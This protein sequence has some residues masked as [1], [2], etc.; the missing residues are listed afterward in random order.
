MTRDEMMQLEEIASKLIKVLNLPQKVITEDMLESVVTVINGIPNFIV[1]E[2]HFSDKFE[3]TNNGIVIITYSLDNSVSENLKFVLNSLCY[4]LLNI[5]NIKN[6]TELSKGIVMQDEEAN[7]LSR[8]ITLP[9][10]VFVEE[11]TANSTNDGLVNATKM[12]KQL[13]MKDSFVV[14]R[15]RDL[16]FFN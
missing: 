14:R 3:I 10:G 4:G 6:N 2:D 8:A 1:V 7:Y 16:N 9:K 15:G 5:D 13:K 12:A 11:I